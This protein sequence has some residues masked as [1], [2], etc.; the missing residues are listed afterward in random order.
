MTQVLAAQHTADS[1]ANGFH[2]NTHVPTNWTHIGHLAKPLAN[3]HWR[4]S[5]R[6]PGPEQWH[7]YRVVLSM[8]SRMVPVHTDAL[9]RLLPSA[10]V[11]RKGQPGMPDHLDNWV[12]GP[13]GHIHT[14]DSGI[15]H[16]HEAAYQA[17]RDRIDP[18][19]I[20]ARRDQRRQERMAELAQ[21]R[22]VRRERLLAERTARR[23]VQQAARQASA[24]PNATEATVAQGIANAMQAVHN[25]VRPLRPNPDA[26]AAAP[27]PAPVAAANPAPAPA[28][29]LAAAWS[30][31][32]EQVPS[33]IR[34]Q[35]E[36]AAQDDSRTVTCVV[37]MDAMPQMAFT[38]CGHAVSCQSCTHR[39]EGWGSATGHQRRKCPV[40][41]TS[42]GVI[43]IHFG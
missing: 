10:K 30:L 25:L 20:Q 4:N 43:R 19:R 36:Q 37:C 13:K 18:V 26:A 38:E 28:L 27:N 3:T 35:A 41:R 16:T 2:P 7:V 29:D 42:G 1:Q 5:N 17:R 14:M 34:A 33:L 9:S 31:L 39:L 21:R 12:K 11:W 6:T 8:G 24:A 15:A 40:C 22:A 32:Q 23:A